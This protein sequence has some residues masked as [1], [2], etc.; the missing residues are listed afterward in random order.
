M[1]SESHHI[2]HRVLAAESGHLLANVLIDVTF[3]LEQVLQ[4]A[5]LI[6]KVVHFQLQ[7]LKLGL[8]ALLLL[9]LVGFQYSAIEGGTTSNRVK[10]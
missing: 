10:L 7:A 5:V 2:T 1:E 6:L 3:L 4:L 8:I 9:V